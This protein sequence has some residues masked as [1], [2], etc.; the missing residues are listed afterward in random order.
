MTY[1]EISDMAYT[2]FKEPNVPDAYAHMLCD[3]YS[4]ANLRDKKE[5]QD[6]IESKIDTNDVPF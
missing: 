4:W 1:R 6:A 5:R 3:L 2:L